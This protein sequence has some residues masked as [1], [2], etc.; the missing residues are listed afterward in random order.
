MPR[1]YSKMR[2]DFVAYLRQDLKKLR[3]NDIKANERSQLNRRIVHTL[4]LRL[5]ISVAQMVHAAN[6][7]GHRILK[8][9]TSHAIWL[10]SNQ[11]SLSL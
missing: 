2:I 9:G 1:Q 10:S 6:D 11:Q 5:L 8:A 4:E 7:I 3:Q